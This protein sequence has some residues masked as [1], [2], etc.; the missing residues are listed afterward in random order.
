MALEEG[1]GL[2]KAIY[3][4]CWRFEKKGKRGLIEGFEWYGPDIE[5]QVVYENY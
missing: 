4:I 3:D 5:D 1:E 2:K